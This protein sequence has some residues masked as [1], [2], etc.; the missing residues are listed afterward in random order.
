M[1][2]PAGGPLPLERGP[3]DANL[4]APR[5]VPRKARSAGARAPG[6]PPRPSRSDGEAAVAAD[7]FEAAPAPA[8][9]PAA[10]LAPGRGPAK[11]ADPREAVRE[12]VLALEQ[13]ARQLAG[14]GDFEAQQLAAH[15]IKLARRIAD[16]AGSGRAAALLEASRALTVGRRDRT[17]IRL[18][19][20]VATTRAGLEDLL[21]KAPDEAERRRVRALVEVYE[22]L[23]GCCRELANA[24]ISNNMARRKLLVPKVAAAAAKAKEGVEAAKAP[25]PAKPPA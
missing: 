20:L 9:A 3:Q 14:S 15:A 23:D 19:E 24:V 5:E 6:A 7:E 2:V 11:P 13:R 10:A 1:Q 16:A 25:G 21:R 22:E 8:S 18:A 17:T 4:G 12:R